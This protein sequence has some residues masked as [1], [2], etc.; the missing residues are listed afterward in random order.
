MKVKTRDFY[1]K[2]LNYAL[3]PTPNFEGYMSNP[4]KCCEDNQYAYDVEGHQTPDYPST[5]TNIIRQ[6]LQVLS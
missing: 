5:F 3:M 6:R 2:N 4:R 1:L